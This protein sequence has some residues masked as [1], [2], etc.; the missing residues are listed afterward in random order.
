MAQETENRPDAQACLTRAE[1]QAAAA[2]IE[3]IIDNVG[4]VIL[5]KREAVELVV[6]ALLSEGH[7]LLEDVPG[8]GK[9][10]LVS[11]VAKSVDCDFSRIQFTPDLMP[12]DVCGFSVYNQ[13]SGEFEFRPGGVMS[14]LVLADEINRAS[15]KT[16]AALLEAMEEKQVTVD[17]YTYKLDEPF[18][19][20]AT[21]NPIESF[22]TYPLPDA[23][24]DR[25]LLKMSVGYLDL[26]EEAKVIL[27]PKEHKKSVRPV[28]G[29]NEV[30]ALVALGRRVRVEP[31]LAT[32]IAEIVAAT[33]T[34]ADTVLGSSPRGGIFLVNASR[35]YAMMQGREYVEPEDIRY[36]APHILAHR[37]TLT[38][39]ATVAGKSQKDVVQAVLGSVAVPT[40]EPES[41]KLPRTKKGSGKKGFGQEDAGENG[42][43]GDVTAGDET[44]RT[45]GN[46]AAV[47]AGNQSGSGVS[48][49]AGNGSGDGS[50]NGPSADRPG[51]KGASAGYTDKD[52]VGS[53]AGYDTQD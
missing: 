43:T 46:E 18:M 25:F 51:A 16:Q 14:N 42:N 4:T 11:A 6:L 41:N 13:K 29:K 44:G 35:V 8:V 7:V 17:S 28:V 10:S 19:V 1:A 22:G 38:H 39:E 12:S 15:A 24:L 48:G 53:A 49:S 21:Q 26:Q 45:D 23:Q 37:L 36:L 20:M 5:G 27:M 33:R 52:T 34:S 31:M 40:G 50:G 3:K 32:Y 30:R 47:N 9:T 2:Q